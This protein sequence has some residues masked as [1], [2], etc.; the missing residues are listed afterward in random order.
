[1][2]CVS[3]FSETSAI[4]KAGHTDGTFY[5]AHDRFFWLAGDKKYIIDGYYNS[6]N[7]WKG[8]NVHKIAFNFMYDRSG[9]VVKVGV[10]EMRRKTVFLTEY[11]KK[12]R[13]VKDYDYEAEHFPEPLGDGEM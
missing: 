12:L 10:K 2:S 5:Y 8:K 3:N 4:G 6:D 11:Y 9:D 1:M 7:E 13:Y